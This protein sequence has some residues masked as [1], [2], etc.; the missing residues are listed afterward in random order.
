VKLKFIIL[1]FIICLNISQAF[2]RPWSAAEAPHILVKNLITSFD[3]LPA[4]AQIKNEFLIWPSSHWANHVGGIANR[5]SAA[6]PQNFRYKFLAAQALRE[7]QDNERAELSPAEKYDIYTSRYDYPTV[8]TVWGQTS[9][10]DTTW[11]GI[12]HGVAPASIHHPEPETVKMVNAEGVELIFYSS[13]VTALMSYYYAKVAK[14]PVRQVGKRCFR[15]E[16]GRGRRGAMTSCQG[17]N[18]A[19]FHLVLTNMLGL[20][21]QS[22]VVDIDRYNEVWNHVPKSFSFDVYGEYGVEQTTTFG[23]TKRLWIGLTVTYAGDIAPYF[24]PVIGTERGIYLDNNYQYFLDLDDNN[25]IIGGEWISDL[26]PD[27]VWFKEKASFSG[28]FSKL[29]EIY[30]ARQE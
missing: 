23:A 5:W 18:P 16:D 4:K 3:Q 27:F 26:R 22:L 9:P 8:K 14:S 2:A 11:F 28:A 21:N 10:R 20:Q 29:N 17:L 24:E 25:N 19:S 12:C 6:N 15:T 13:D 7:L 30:Q 1:L